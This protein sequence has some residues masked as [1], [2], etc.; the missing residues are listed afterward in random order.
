MEVFETFFATCEQSQ[1]YLKAS[2]AK[3]Q[4]IAGRILD[5]MTDMFRSPQTAVKDISALGL[6]HA[7]YGVREELIPPFVTAFMT[8]VKN[9]CPEESWL[10]GVQ[11]TF[12]VVSRTLARTLAEGS[13]AVMRAITK[14]SARQLEE[15][16]S[17]APRGQR[18]QMLLRV[19]VGTESISPF[20]WAIQSG[21][22]RSAEAILKDLLTIRADRA[23]YYYGM[24]GLWDRHPDIVPLLCKQAPSLM[25]HLLDG[26]MWRSKQIKGGMR[27]V[28][29]YISRILVTETGQ[30][31]PSMQQLVKHGDPNLLC[32]PCTRFVF[33]LL[34]ARMCCL[35]FMITKLWF[36]VT[37]LDFIVGLQY[38]ILMFDSAGPGRWALISCRL[39][40]YIFSLGQLFIKHTAQIAKAYKEQRTVRCFRGLTLPSYLLSSRQE[41]VEFTLAVFLFV[42]LT[43][44]PFLHCLNV[45]D[46]FVTNCCEHGEFY[47]TLSDNYDRIST[48]PMLLYFV[49]AADLIHLNIHLSSFVVICTSL[50]WEFVLYLGALVFLATAFASAIACLPQTGLDDSVQL[51]DFYNWPSA[52][53]SLLSMSLNMYS[54]NNFEE[55]SVATEVPLKWWIIGF[56]A[57]WHVFLTNLM[58]AHFCESWLTRGKDI[59]ETAMP[60]ISAKKWKAFVESLKL[61]EPCEL[62]EGD[63]GPHGGVA[64]VEGPFEHLK[65]PSVDLDRVQRFGGLASVEL[66]WPEDKSDNE[67][68][69]NEKLQKMTR[70]RFD[71]Q[72]RML[73]EICI[74]LG[75]RASGTGTGSSAGSM[76]AHSQTSDRPRTKL[77]VVEGS[78]SFAAGEDTIPEDTSAERSDASATEFMEGDPSRHNSM[79]S[80]RNWGRGGSMSP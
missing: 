61:E 12:E 21:A 55:I 8:A 77:E 74:K 44:E 59:L 4:F 14:N 13:T 75:I 41:F 22:L 15:A 24:E 11:W 25:E 57:C 54:G 19:Q 79:Q 45:D 49:L 48:L 1:E 20:L 3:L 38:G 52:F 80:P 42:M 2:N 67:D 28:N 39:F 71:E 37:L 51:R 33:D 9:A 31:A 40:M 26:L 70:A 36:V 58:I 60:L 32:H 30:L 7:G 10:K 76:I 64:T 29:Y 23:R 62:D 53:Q 34:W 35:A 73:R 43:M 17:S 16:V 47:C 68:S 6:L 63:V 5:I 69:C 46:R 65:S 27:R 72:D 66:P 50:W 78:G 56:G 18:E